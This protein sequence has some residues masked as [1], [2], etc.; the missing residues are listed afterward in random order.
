MSANYLYIVVAF[1]AVLLLLAAWL[2]VIELR[3]KKIFRGK[4]G[5]DLEDALGLVGEELK[6]LDLS[7]EEMEKYLT[8]VEKRLKKSVHNVGAVRFNP[9][10][11]AGSNQSFSIAL[12][13]ENKDGVVVSSLYSRERTNIYAKPVK[14]GKSEYPLTEEEEQAIKMTQNET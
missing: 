11:D 3:L 13:D 10:E 1:G 9:F 14:D 7:R 8:E 5:S 2:L 6:K 12:L 4:R